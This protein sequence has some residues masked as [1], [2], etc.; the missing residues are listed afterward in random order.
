MTLPTPPLGSGDRLAA[1]IGDLAKT[2]DDRA[3]APNSRSYTSQLL[4]L[5]P[6]ACAKKLGEEAV[7][8]ALA[9]A[10]QDAGSVAAEAADLLYHL[11]VGLRSRG[12]SLDAVAD[13]LIS[14][15]SRSGL[16]EKAARTLTSPT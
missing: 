5:G 9:I 13:I 11:L 7:E 2:I 8:T 6:S 12:A 10:G 14:R 4:G 1:A 3:S 16:E 15:S